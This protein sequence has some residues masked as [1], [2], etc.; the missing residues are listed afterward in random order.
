MYGIVCLCIVF[1]AFSHHQ[2][3]PDLI[4]GDELLISKVVLSQWRQAV[5]LGAQPIT[6]LCGGRPVYR[7]DSLPHIWYP[8]PYRSLDPGQYREEWWA[9][10]N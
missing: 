7:L 8:T 3:S 6:D 9:R 10:D 5:S 4:L 2:E 1:A